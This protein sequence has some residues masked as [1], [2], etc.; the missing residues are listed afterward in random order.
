M[1]LTGEKR[2]RRVA[3]YRAGAIEDS[4]E[5]REEYRRW[6]IDRLLRF[7]RIF[8]PKLQQAAAAAAPAQRSNGA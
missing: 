1:E 4:D 5:N 8:G 2:A 3:C 7:K 6:A